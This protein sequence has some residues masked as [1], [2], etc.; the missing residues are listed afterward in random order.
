MSEQQPVQALHIFSDRKFI[1]WVRQTFK[2]FKWTSTFIILRSD[3]KNKHASVDEQTTEV[4]ADKY[5]YSFVLRSIHSNDIILHYLL[6][7]HKANIISLAP[8]D[9]LHFWC[10]YGTEVYQQTPYF[11]KN[12]YGPE[13]K[14][15]LRTLPEIKFRYELRK[16]FYQIGKFEKTPLQSLKEAIPHI[17]SILWYVG[18]EIEQIKTKMELPPWKFFQFFEPND[19]IPEGTKKVNPLSRKILLGNSATIEN[20]HLDAL[21]SL[22]LAAD[23]GYA[24]TLPLTYGQFPRYKK[25]IKSRFAN[26]LGNHVD[27]L[28]KHLSLDDYYSHLLEFPTAVFLHRRQQALGN[29]LFLLYAGTKIYLSESNVIYKWLTA[30]Q[31]KVSIFEADFEND[32]K[33]NQLVWSTDIIEHNRLHTRLLLEHQKN[34]ATI[35][36]MEQLAYERRSSNE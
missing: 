21:R 20:N 35:Q 16:L 17:R 29:I 27:F 8:S 11:R 33:K 6:D 19:I 18:E 36:W 30:N 2:Q 7:N 15:L 14:K 1:P 24:V 4:S 23:A 22:R 25:K 10:F 34:K 3:W 32:V 26:D 13:S 28:E 9:T 31:I 12:L 5:G